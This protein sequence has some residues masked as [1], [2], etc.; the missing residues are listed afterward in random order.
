VLDHSVEEIADELN[1]SVPAVKAALHR[2]R[3]VLHRAAQGQLIQPRLREIS[4]ALLRYAALFNS[5]DWDGVRA[6]LADDVRL[7][8]VS[9]RKAAGRREV[10]IYFTNYSRM[11]DWRLAPAWLD[12]REVLS[13]TVHAEATH[14]SQGTYFIELTFRDDRV[15]VI[16]DFRHVPYISQEA[17]FELPRH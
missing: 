13:V 12:G 5:R 16:R 11:N 6:M 4:P 9:R 3:S 8:L 1:L 15:A 10:A 2:G 17:H 14:S 7:D